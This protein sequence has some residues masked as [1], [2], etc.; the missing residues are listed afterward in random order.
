TYDGSTTAPI[1]AGTYDVEVTFISDDP[2]YLSTSITS[3][4]TILPATPSVGLDNGGQWEFTYN[5]SPQSVVGSAAGI[6]GVTPVAGSF[7][8]T[9]YDYYYPYTQLSGAPTNAGY[10]SFTE[11][12]TS[13]DPNYSDGSFSWQMIID[14]TTPTV[15]VSG[16]PLTYNGT[17]QR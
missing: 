1:N 6:D 12:F 16:G 9:Y 8:Y 4:I 2:N 10:Y 17:S 15:T 7:S 14:P 3:S 11:Y 13:Q 5:G